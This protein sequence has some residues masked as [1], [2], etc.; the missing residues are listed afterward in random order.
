MYDLIIVGAGAAG[1]SAGLYA[2]RREMKTLIIS[3]DLGGQTARAGTIEN[4][5]GFEPIDG[6]E[7]MEKFKNQAEKSGI[8]TVYDEV[9]EIKKENG[10]EVYFNIKLASSQ[11][12]KSKT[13][14]LCFGLTPRD[15]GVPGEQE[16]KTKG[17]TYC[18]T[19][20]APLYKGKDVVVVGGG[21][22]ALDAAELLS[23][24]ANKVYLVHRNE[25]FRSEK[26]MIDRVKEA[27]NVEVLLHTELKEIKGDQFVSSVVVKDKGGQEK[28]L[29]A[30]GVF[31]EIG[32]IAKTDLLK[33]LVD[34]NEKNEIITSKDCQTSV[35]GLF[36]AGDI[37]DIPYKQIVISAGEGVKAAL[38]AY[39][40]IQ[41]EQGQIGLDWGVAKK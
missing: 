23:K 18:A 1:L 22:S 32:F 17:V 5:P 35:P 24:V 28:E 39:R 20:D 3:K 11:E 16:F 30:S 10:E 26:V 29:S 38:Q 4:Y 8:E 31:I 25:M 21:N 40:Y 15:L 14:L 9:V 41:R 13:L 7:L 12:Y 33:G 2:G 6:F 19:C 36:A 37:T 27:K 34:L